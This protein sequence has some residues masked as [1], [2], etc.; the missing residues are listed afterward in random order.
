MEVQPGGFYLTAQGK[1]VDASGKPV[2]PESWPESYKVA[3]ADD[4]EQK[5]V[6]SPPPAN[7]TKR[8]RK[9]R[10]KTS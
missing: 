1:P 7:K 8:T 6:S 10:A 3:Q 9:A 4:P 5:S 2:P